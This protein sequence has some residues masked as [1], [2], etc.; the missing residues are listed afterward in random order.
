MEVE[1]AEKEVE[2]EVARGGGGRAEAED[3]RVEGV[4]E[5]AEGES[6]EG[7]ESL[8]GAQGAGGP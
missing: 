5:G 6:M 3:P 2:Q 4:K 1:V 8:G 7:G